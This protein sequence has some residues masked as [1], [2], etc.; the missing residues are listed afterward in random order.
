[1]SILKDLKEQRRLWIVPPCGHSFRAADAN[2]FD[3]TRPLKGE[4]LELLGRMRQE[5][6][7]ERAEFE[8]SKS[9]TEQTSR[10]T[11]RAVTIGNVVEKI[12]PNLPGFPLTA[13]DCRSLFEPIDY[14][15]FKGLSVKGRVDALGFVEIKSGNSQ[16][17]REQRAVRALVEAGKVE[18]VVA[19]NPEQK[20]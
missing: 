15:L 10:T 11:A 17:T 8:A 7:D 3:A 4:A 16:L 2:L 1:M 12:A 19:A 13:A 5:L 6:R 14:V 9:K 20:P 18:Y